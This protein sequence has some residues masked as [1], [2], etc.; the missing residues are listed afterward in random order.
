MSEYPGCRDHVRRRRRSDR[1]GTADLLP[2]AAARGGQSAMAVPDGHSQAA[3]RRCAH[4]TK[5]TAA[6]HATDRRP[7]PCRVRLVSLLRDA[8]GEVSGLQLT[9]LDIRGRLSTT[10]PRRQTYAL[11]P[12]GVRDALFR[13]PG[14]PETGDLG[15]PE[16][17]QTGFL[18]EG[19]CEKPLALAAAGLL[20]S[21]G[22][23][24]L[25]TL[26]YA[27]PPE[28]IAVVVPDKAPADEAAAALHAR[29]MRV[30]LDRLVLAGREVQ[31]APPPDCA[32]SCCK[33]ADDYL[34]R[35]GPGRLAELVGRAE[36]GALSLDGEISV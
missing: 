30:G 31:L 4:R 10:E 1:A 18:A 15:N 12:N 16:T 24:G 28:P 19:F 34:R 32:G 6:A 13:V 20:P 5:R 25:T 29:A 36:T 22:W 33:D 7:R 14:S 17:P 8:S 35:H 21:Y 23:G 27:I 11:R 9:F 2:P 26:G 3:S